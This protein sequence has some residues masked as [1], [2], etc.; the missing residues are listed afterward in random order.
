MGRK[1]YMY[2]T[3]CMKDNTLRVTSHSTHGSSVAVTCVNLKP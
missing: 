3:F 2:G 1:E